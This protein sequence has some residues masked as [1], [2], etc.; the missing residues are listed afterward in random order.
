VTSP[1]LTVIIPTR[2]RPENL[3]GQLRLFRRTSHPVVVA[4][5]SDPDNAARIRAITADIAAYRAF[6]PELTLYAKLDRALRD[7]ETPFV[8]LVADRKITF[9]HAVDALLAHL[10][11]HEDT[12][13]A[14]GYI[15]GFKAHPDTIDINRV[16]WFT[17]TI[18]EDDPLQRHYHLMRRYQSRGFGAF[19]LAPLR[20]AV[21]QAQR[22]EGAV[23]QETLMMN[24]LALQGKMARLPVILSLQSQERS[25]HP[26]KRNDPL[27]WFLDDSRSF[28]LHYASYRTALTDFI[29]ELGIAPPPH[30]SL[31]Q[32]VDMVHAVWLHRNFDDGMLNHAARL[33]LGDPMEPIPGPDVRIPWRKPGWRDIVRRGARRYVWRR[34]VL[35]A[36]PRHEIHISR[37]E[38][39]RVTDQLDVY[40]GG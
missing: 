3:P 8:V 24:A 31:D 30:S 2:N 4:D 7:V 23:F 9:P 20:R 1:L 6:P 36:E 18:G 37:Q 15:V 38:V 21:A 10:L 35:R 28:A 33:L 14:M 40:F 34:D 13:S 32:L 22:V 16:I 29:R 11:A 27:Y 12:V 39:Q 19:G 17:P 25:F 5:S 26:P